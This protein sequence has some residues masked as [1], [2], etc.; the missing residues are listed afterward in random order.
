MNARRYINPQAIVVFVAAVFAL[1][2]AQ[3]GE[4]FAAGI[5]VGAVVAGLAATILQIRV[6]R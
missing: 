5:A 3:A 6:V 2:A 1:I 4:T